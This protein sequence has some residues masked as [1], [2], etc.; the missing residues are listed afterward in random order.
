MGKTTLTPEE[1]RRYSRHLVLPHVGIAGQEKLKAASVMIIG[2]GG[3]GSPV[4]L[5]L[6]AAGVGRLGL[7]DFD[8]V[9]ES[10]L[11]RQILH[12]TQ[13]V[14]RS[15]LESAREAIHAIN[16]HVQV[17]LHETR[18]TSDNAM[19]IAA[20]YDMIIDGTDNFPTRYLVN[21]VCVL[22]DRPNIYGS[23]YRFEGQTSVFWARRG[24]CYR[25]LY[26]APPPPE[27]VPS[28][29]V[30]GVL[31]V[32]PGLIGTIQATEAVKLI[33]GEGEPLIGRLLLYDALRMQFREVGLSKNPD[34]P[35]CGPNRTIHAP[36]DYHEFCGVPGAEEDI[37]V[38]PEWEV[39]PKELA[40]KWRSQDI[41]ILDVREPLEWD[42]GH[43]DGAVQ[44]PLRELSARLGELEREREIVAYC[45]SGQRSALALR[46]LREA[47]FAKAKHLRGGL[48]AWRED[49]DPSIPPY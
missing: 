23:V 21:D 28:C 37:S 34:C 17:D 3:L 33:L 1:F 26:P 15:K 44:I 9:D 4:A 39:T 30:G 19:H 16:P 47:G 40:E 24:P 27:M 14:G 7:V 45:R 38:P 29:A 25:C 35:I 12:K 8:V 41:T 11:Q 32:L 5:Y 10:N 13:N 2:A 22:L 6:A 20:D 49:I 31:G 18:F 42:I 48:L 46:I 43:I 36:I